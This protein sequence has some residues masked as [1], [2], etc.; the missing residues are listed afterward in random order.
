MAESWKW[1]LERQSGLI[2]FKVLEA[3]GGRKGLAESPRIKRE[4]AGH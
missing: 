1:R 2:S 3:V 4:R